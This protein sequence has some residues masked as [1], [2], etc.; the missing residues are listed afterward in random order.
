[1]LCPTCQIDLIAPTTL[2]HVYQCPQCG[3]VF[4]Q[5]CPL[6]PKKLVDLIT[7]VRTWKNIMFDDI[8]GEPLAQGYAYDK[9]KLDELEAILGRFEI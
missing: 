2:K 7:Q 1:M 6:D 4:L 5:K 9:K 3:W 8:L